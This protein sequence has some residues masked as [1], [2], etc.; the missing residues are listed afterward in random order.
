MIE[1]LT[2][3]RIETFEKE[4]SIIKSLLTKRGDEIITLSKNYP[5]I[6]L[7]VNSCDDVDIDDD[8]FY[9]KEDW[10]CM[11]ESGRDYSIAFPIDALYD[12]NALKDFFE[13]EENKFFEKEKQAQIIKEK[14]ER[15][16]FERLK[17]K[18]EK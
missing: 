14:K 16:E 4:E 1:G 9:I 12:D 5:H 8:C 10:D 11:G 6:Y 2:K 3:E 18:F 15:A 13:K 7:N 17:A